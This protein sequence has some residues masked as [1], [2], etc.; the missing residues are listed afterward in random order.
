M[1]WNKNDNQSFVQT[2]EQKNLSI[3]MF[4]STCACTLFIHINSNCG[5][6]IVEVSKNATHC[7]RI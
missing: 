5:L 7:S 6:N 3:D 2:T 4:E 1:K